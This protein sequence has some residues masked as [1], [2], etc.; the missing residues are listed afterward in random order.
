MDVDVLA[1][2]P[3]WRQGNLSYWSHQ[4]GIEQGWER[5]KDEMSAVVERS[6]PKVIYLKTGV[7]EAYQWEALLIGLGYGGGIGWETSYYGGKNFQIVA[8]P[9]LDLSY[10]PTMP[11]SRSAT[12]ELA[13]WLGQC[14]MRSACDVCAGKGKMLKKFLDEGMNVVACELVETRAA[15]CAKRLLGK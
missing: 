6:K 3:P 12:T 14:G 2:D 4:A 13:K 1:V 15:E 7:P 11:E 5:F 8:S 9:V 10:C